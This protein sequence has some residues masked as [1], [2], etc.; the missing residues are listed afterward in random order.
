MSEKDDLA[1]LA[2]DFID[3]W[4]EHVAASATDPALIEWAEAWMAPVTAATRRRSMT[5]APPRQGPRPL[6]ST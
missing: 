2:R 6:A 5:G 3:L 1:K 4:Q